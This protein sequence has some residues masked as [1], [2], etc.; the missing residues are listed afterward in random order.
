MNISCIKQIVYKA[1]TFVIQCTICID[2]IQ[3]KPNSLCLTEYCNYLVPTTFKEA[4]QTAD[5][6]SKTNHHKHNQHWQP[7]YLLNKMSELS[8]M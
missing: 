1:K 4:R 6:D 8:A 2:S 3:N 7:T 5:V